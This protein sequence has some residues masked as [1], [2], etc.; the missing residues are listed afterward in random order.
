MKKALFLLMICSNVFCFGQ[1]NDP[2]PD[3]NTGKNDTFYYLP[4]LIDTAKPYKKIIQKRQVYYGYAGIQ[5]KQPIDSTKYYFH[6]FLF[7]QDKMNKST[8]RNFARYEDS[9]IRYYK[10]L[11][12]INK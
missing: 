11:Y 5:K 10:L 4:S 12:K 3:A 7:F 2:F 8:G 6:K 1:K 9:T